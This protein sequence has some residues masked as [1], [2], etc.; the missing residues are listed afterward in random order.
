MKS[1]RS[2]EPKKNLKP[3][4]KVKPLKFNAIV[5]TDQ[6]SALVNLN[7][8]QTSTAER[9]TLLTKKQS[10]FREAKRKAKSEQGETSVERQTTKP[11][12]LKEV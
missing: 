12:I 2:E 11:I 8:Y 10:S 9:L 5:L 4:R 6:L 7:E 3:I 1:E